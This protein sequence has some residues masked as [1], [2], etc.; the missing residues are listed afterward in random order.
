MKLLKFLFLGLAVL[1][2][3]YGIYQ[4]F[5][6]VRVAQ[7]SMEYMN[8][9]SV[10]EVSQLYLL[11]GGSVLATLTLIFFCFLGVKITSLLDGPTAGEDLRNLITKLRT[12][13]QKNDPTPT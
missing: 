11:N 6:V 4:I 1:H 5:S 7:H 13:G 2:T 8:A 12:L 9:P 10:W 3:L